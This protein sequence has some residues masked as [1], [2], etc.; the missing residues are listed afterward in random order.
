MSVGAAQRQS[1]RRVWQT[2]HTV[3]GIYKGEERKGHSR[4]EPFE[5]LDVGRPE[6]SGGFSSE[7]F[8]IDWA[9][10]AGGYEGATRNGRVLPSAALSILVSSL[11]CAQ[12]V[13]RWW[14]PNERDLSIK[15]VQSAVSESETTR[16]AR[17]HGFDTVWRSSC[18]RFKH[19]ARHSAIRTRNPTPNRCCSLNE[20][21]SL[22][23]R[24]V[25][26]C[27]QRHRR[28]CCRLV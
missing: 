27:H 9:T 18:S 20:N 12:P 8:W 26:C 17:S 7:H 15:C 23:C 16:A 13:N 10:T 22:E 2:G 21:V 28:T 19:C 14:S 4:R 3:G 5:R 11:R 25:F 1:K 6:C 24:P